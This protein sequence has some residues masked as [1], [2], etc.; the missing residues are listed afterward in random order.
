MNERKVR[1]GLWEKALLIVLGASILITTIIG[2]IFYSRLVGNVK[3]NYERNAKTALQVC[4]DAFD[5]AMKEAYFTCVYA[6]GGDELKQAMQQYDTAYT[7]LI[8]LLQEYRNS[9]S[10]I[11]SVY[12][13]IKDTD[14]IIKVSANGVQI[15][16][17]TLDISDW[18]DSAT[19][20]NSDN[21]LS[22][23]YNTDTTSA[24]QRQYF[25]YGKRV[26]D[27]TQNELGR[28]FVNVD[29]RTIYFKCLRQENS[30]NNKAYIILNDSIVSSADVSQLG[31]NIPKSNDV[32]TVSAD[33]VMTDYSMVSVSDLSE[34]TG[35]LRNARN[36]I[37]LVIILMNILFAVPEILI[38]RSIMKPVREMEKTMEQVMEGDMSVRAKVYHQDEIGHLSTIFNKMI[39]QIEQLIDEL[40]T[41]KM[42]KKEAEIEALQYQITP[43][44]MYN[45]L[46]SIRYAAKLE[47]SERI[48]D[49]LQAFT[50]LLRMSAS[51][52]GAFITV[53][54]E[55][56]MVRNYAMLQKFRYA[57]S[58]DVHINVADGTEGFYVPRLIVQPLVEN[59]ILHGLDHKQE[60]NEIMI[61]VSQDDK[62]LILKVSDSGLGMTHEKVQELMNGTHR[63]KFSGI[64]ISNIKERLRL[65]YG[66]R[67][68]LKYYSEQGQ[69]TVAVMVIPASDDP[70]AYII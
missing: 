49:L 45:T 47:H 56:Q 40:V 42:L 65:Y 23:K 5:A 3:D 26:Y 1:F 38:I 16:S 67:G 20:Y 12:C 52:R 8:E 58:F 54:Q 22:P 11:Y 63:N 28:I 33:A 41:E 30:N 39:Q 46:S 19:Q 13:Y 66:D 51:D 21:A 61:S 50:E 48:A 36:W 60:N 44:F 43:H 7:D 9:N 29:E 68:K 24:I 59:A 25:T 17:N 14:E 62:Y 6:A 64:G 10:E 55:M 32:I 69:G 34:L 53:Q 27:S 35:D 57:D 70:E 31:Q 15:E 37:L 18:M 2:I 4:I